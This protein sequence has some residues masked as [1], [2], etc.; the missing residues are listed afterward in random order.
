MSGKRGNRIC[1]SMTSRKKLYISTILFILLALSIWFIILDFSRFYSHNYSY[2]I[3]PSA[4]LKRI[5][6]ILAA[7]LV[8]VTGKDRL[9]LT[10]SRRMKAAF[11]FII[12][13]EAAFAF[14]ARAIGVGMFAVCQILLIVRNSTG[15]KYK[16]K[17]ASDAQKKELVISEVIIVLILLLFAFLFASFNRG[18]NTAIAIYIYGII[19]SIS[20]CAGLAN[21]ILVLL[22]KV[23]SIMVAA[24]MI[25]FFCCD[26]LVGFDAAMEAGVP[27]LLVNSF[28]WVFYIPA[29]VLLALSCYRYNK[30]Q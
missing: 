18:F 24:G 23:N 20:L 4:L 10:D 13:G 1:K 28:I 26:V 25:C 5:N 30:I 22:P 2:D 11:I 7:F 6:V 29:L 16:L 15:L 3:Y 27:W 12:L 9:S 19:L 8:W 14:G 21:S 17:R